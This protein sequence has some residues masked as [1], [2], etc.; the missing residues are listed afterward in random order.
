MGEESFSLATCRP[1]IPSR[2]GRSIL[3]PA[4]RSPLRLS[5]PVST[6]AAY[7]KLE[8]DFREKVGLP[9]REAEGHTEEGK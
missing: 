6:Q 7:R 1:A 8:A 3:G 2:E 9:P 5:R 4:P